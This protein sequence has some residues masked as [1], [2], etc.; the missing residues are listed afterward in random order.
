MVLPTRGACLSPATPHAAPASSS[1]SPGGSLLDSRAAAPRVTRIVFLAALCVALLASPAPGQ[2]LCTYPTISSRTPGTCADAP[3]RCQGHSWEFT[4]GTYEFDIYPHEVC[5]SWLSGMRFG[6]TW[7]AAWTLVSW[8]TC[9]GTTATG[10]L[11]APGDGLLLAFSPCTDGNTAVVRVVMDCTAPGRMSFTR[12]PD[13]EIAYRPC[14]SSTWV[15]YDPIITYVE[16]GDY[17]GREVLDNPCG[18]LCSSPLG[19]VFDPPV[20]DAAVYE[21]GTAT[22]ALTAAFIDGCPRLPECGGWPMGTCVSELEAGA[23][24]MTV[25]FLTEGYAGRRH[26]AVHLDTNGL[27][28][29][30]HTARIE[31]GSTTCSD[32]A[33]NCVEVRLEVLPCGPPLRPGD[34]PLGI[35]RRV[36]DDHPTI[37]AALAAASPGD[38]VAVRAGTYP[39]S[40][41][42]RDGVAVL[43]GYD[44]TFTLRDVERYETIL[45]ASGRVITCLGC[46]GPTGVVDGFTITTT[47][48][49]DEDGGLVL[50]RDAAPTLTHNRFVGA[51]GQRGGALCLAGSGALVA[52]NVF[53][54]CSSSAGGGALFLSG[55]TGTTIARCRFE[56][57]A[58]TGSGGGVLIDQ[59]FAVTVT[60]CFF[61]DNEATQAGGGLLVQES[62]VTMERC[63]L[64]GNSA[65]Q[66]GGM[67]VFSPYESSFV[68]LTTFGNDAAD[69]GGL[70]FSSWSRG[71]VEQSILAGNHGYGIAAGYGATVA[72]DCNDA[73]ANTPLD[74]RN[75][76]AGPASISSD[77][78]FCAAAS[79]DFTIDADS[80][81]A[82]AHS[83]G[84]DL[85]G[86]L[87]PV[88]VRQVIR[89]P[90]DEPTVLAAVNRAAGGDTVKVA[91]GH[92]RER[93][94]L[95]DR[96]RLYGGYRSD[97]AGRDPV[98]Y[99]TILDAGGFLTTVV[100]Q[101]GQSRFTEIDGF[102]ITG[103]DRAGGFGGG[104]ECFGSSPTIRHNVIRGNRAAQGAAI[105]G[106]AGSAPVIAGNLIFDN[107]ADGEPGGAI[108]VDAAAVIEGNTLDANTGPL[109][110]GIVVRAGARPVVRRNIVVNGRTGAGIYADQGAVPQTSCNDAWH[111]AGAD[112]FGVLPGPNALNADPRFCPGEE[113][114]LAADS[115][116]APAIAP[117]VCGLI[118]AR[119]VGCTAAGVL[120]TAAPPGPAVHWMA[121]AGPNPM[122]GSML[123][124][125]GLARAARVRL[126]IAD[127]AGRHVRTLVDGTEAAGAHEAGWNGR[128][129]GGQTVA[130]GV[131]FVHLSADGETVGKQKVTLL[132]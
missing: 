45:T 20:I 87:G 112:Y 121:P 127:A 101:S 16:I 88:C 85:I 96:V 80:P 90:D 32:C 43:G 60:D 77:P 132:D 55:A 49:G 7:P 84:C 83:A 14:G 37:A 111:N 86:A 89:V 94:T 25:D 76:T 51:G 29:G 122:P 40:F 61:I 53:T 30:L 35:L 10:N 125:Y 113:R 18:T 123:L 98:L 28:P 82:P 120:E 72:N 3:P 52:D 100:A 108:H 44:P 119:D 131:Y 50:I 2:V 118:G 129:E 58:T 57:G 12:H 107:E 47:G 75:V 67:A 13:G 38:T 68:N 15:L 39:G 115:P 81:C 34:L 116:C 109:A 22:L 27:A 8:E 69:G 48:A 92:Y 128:D 105:A 79:G 91:T 41:T 117:P 104:I 106:R 114:F 6:L 31:S 95:K 9:P 4:T 66:G 103:G 74:Y 5:P 54:G 62:A 19:V 73:W 42:L 110:S 124:R 63:V 93:I 36:P 17:C 99:P 130:S 33:A 46:V 21:S 70:Y 56:G 23:S 11:A 64:A 97:F 78:F 59:S 65:V 71:T 102:E 126:T 26:Y 1:A 24:W